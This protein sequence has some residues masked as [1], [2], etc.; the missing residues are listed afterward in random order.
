[1]CLQDTLI[2]VLNIDTWCVLTCHFIVRFSLLIHYRVISTS[3]I[4]VEYKFNIGTSP[5]IWKFMIFTLKLTFLAMKFAHFVINNAFV[6][7][8]NY[9]VCYV[10]TSVLSNVSPKFVLNMDWIS[11]CVEITHSTRVTRAYWTK[12][13]T[14]FR[15]KL[16][17]DV[18]VKT[19][20]HRRERILLTP[21][22]SDTTCYQML[23][24]HIL[25][26]LSLQWIAPRHE[27]SSA[28]S[29]LQRCRVRK[30]P[31]DVGMSIINLLCETVG[32]FLPEITRDKRG[33]NRA[34]GS[35]SA[36]YVIR[37]E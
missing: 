3:F 5:Q 13:M 28:S 11:L 31:R 36:I 32:L 16:H 35:R 8:R 18:I 6:Y 20:F 7:C 2:C 17:Q 12:I 23:V 26:D 29:Y 37:S 33:I 34:S 30:T 24:T 14:R 9:E 25:P 1:M 21:S 22:V 27:C 15:G 19:H 4:L 10:N